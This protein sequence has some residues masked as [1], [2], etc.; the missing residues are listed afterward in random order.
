M[1]QT[2][3]L[4]P[5]DDKHESWRRSKVIDQYVRVWAHSCTDARIKAARATEKLHL[6]SQTIIESTTIER[7]TSPW[8]LSEVTSCEEDPTGSTPPPNDIVAEDGTRLPI[9]PNTP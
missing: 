6:D 4:T 3:R 9:W 1:P 5:I 7:Q 2:Y 8:G